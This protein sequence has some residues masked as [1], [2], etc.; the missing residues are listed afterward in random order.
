MPNSLINSSLYT[1]STKATQQT[2][3]GLLK[4]IPV[5]KATVN[6]LVAPPF[7][8]FRERIV[9]ILSVFFSLEILW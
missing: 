7:S 1:N 2:N 9:D 6:L 3:Q 8:H 5:F 4:V